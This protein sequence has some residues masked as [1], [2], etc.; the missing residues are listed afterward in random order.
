MSQLSSVIECC[1]QCDGVKPVWD[2][3]T[4]GWLA[5]YIDGGVYCD[6]PPF[7][8]DNLSKVEYNTFNLDKGE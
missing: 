2:W 7:F 8:L 1:P 4:E 5:P 3:K 6:C